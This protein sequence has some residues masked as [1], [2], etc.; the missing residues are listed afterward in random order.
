MLFNCYLDKN[1]Y[2]MSINDRRYEYLCNNFIY[3]GLTPPKLFKGVRWNNGSN[4]GC[5]LG[6]IA[7]VMMARQLK[8]PW[9]TIYEDDAFPR[10]DVLWMF[11]KIKSYVPSDCGLIKI[12]SSSLRRGHKKI[13]NFVFETDGEG[14]SFGSHAYIIRRE[15]YDMFLE[16][17]QVAKVPDVA[18]SHK[19]FEKS[20]YK[21]YGLF[22]NSML[23]IQKNIDNDNIISS[24]GGQRYYYMHPTKYIGCTSGL[25]PEG[26]ED[27]LFS[28][29][30]KYIT[31]ICVVLNDNWKN[32]KKTAQMEEDM[33]Q[34]KDEKGRL[35]RIEEN[36]WKIR[37]DNIGK[38]EYLK[39]EETKDGTEY[40]KIIQEKDIIKKNFK[41]LLCMTSYN[42]PMECLCQIHRFFNSTYT[43]FVMSV[44]VR[45]VDETVYNNQILPEVKKYVDRGKLIIDRRDNSNLLNNLV[46]C[47][48]QCQEDWDY[49]FKI[50]DDDW[51]SSKFLE[52]INNNIKLNCS[53][54][55]PFGGYISDD[56]I[57]VTKKMDSS[58]KEIK[59]NTS[60]CGGTIFAN[61]YIYQIIDDCRNNLGKV[62]T[63]FQKYNMPNMDYCSRYDRGDRED[64]LLCRLIEYNSKKEGIEPVIIKQKNLYSIYRVYDGVLAR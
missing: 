63:I 26:F 35:S 2:C 11:S 7:I 17:L 34:T 64:R 31:K 15:C 20:K 16:N 46:E 48:D 52:T 41:F 39:Y 56:F 55:I 27:K 33:I 23:F 61:N 6:H 60:L 10:P 44:I 12:G 62:R 40:Y 59:N 13:N 47:I 51:Y 8:L 42:R 30:D 28:D 45:G 32:K 19:Y 21:S 3:V 18:M 37:W 50:D 57:T 5:L 36:L 58:I 49:F 1:A 22:L 25:P 9:V 14:V 38:E 29:D 53:K 43:N 4:M 54:K 24:K